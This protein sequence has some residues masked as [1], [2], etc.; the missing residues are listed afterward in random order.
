MTAHCMD[1]RAPIED[2]WARC[3]RCIEIFGSKTY[4]E[5]CA[6]DDE[7]YYSRLGEEESA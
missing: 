2:G 3:P 1:C 5:I 6:E 7:Q 4:R